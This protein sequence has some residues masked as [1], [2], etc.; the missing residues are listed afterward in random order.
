MREVE[1]VAVKLCD[2]TLAD[3]T[4]LHT[5][6]ASRL[7]LPVLP[8]PA[9]VLPG[10][11]VTI[12]LESDA[13][14]RAV[15]AAE[16]GDGR[17]VL[18]AEASPELGVVARVPNAGALPTGQRAAILQ[19]EVRGRITGRHASGW[20]AEHADVELVTESRPT[21]RVEAAAR[22]LRVVLEEVAK[23]RQ[24]RRLP[25]IL[26]TVAE[27]GALVD[28]VTTWSEASDERRLEVLVTVDVAARLDLLTAWAK[29]H[30]AELQV[31]SKIRA[32][33][34]EG[35]DKQQRELPPAPAAA[36]DPQGAGRGRRRRR[37]GLPH[38]ARRAHRGRHA[39]AEGRHGDRQGDRSPGA[40]ELPVARALVGAHVARPRVRDPVGHR[41][42]ETGS[43][44]TRRVRSSTRT[45]TASTT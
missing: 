7:T 6:V 13:A 3:M 16:R 41:A 25:E 12:A 14:Q 33:V 15:D 45:T 24:S 27:P 26:R 21:P 1:R 17:V 43:T 34:T 42:R 28:A 10:A 37:V 18:V 2:A 31:T 11:V 22:E 38:E 30:L 20:G 8:L 40:D 5:G 44:S 36:G 35:V 19:A 23:L 32:D 9:V 29:A 39:R 4:D